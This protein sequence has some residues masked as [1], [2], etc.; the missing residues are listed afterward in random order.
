MDSTAA[1]VASLQVACR[2]LGLPVPA[3]ER[4]RYIIGLGLHDAMSH[5][6]PRRDPS[7]SARVESLRLPLSGGRRRDGVVFRSRGEAAARSAAGYLLAVAT[8]KSRRGLDRALDENRTER[9]FIATR[10]AEEGPAK[11]HPG[12]LQRTD[13]TSWGTIGDD[14]DDRRHHARSADGDQRRRRGVAAAY[15]AHPRAQLGVAAIRLPASIG[16]RSCGNGCSRH[17]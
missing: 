17:A 2:D 15:G 9:C 14:A 1:I 7:L 11:P 12:M 4:A 13:A 16:R 6:A 8:G 10:C 5:V 3:D